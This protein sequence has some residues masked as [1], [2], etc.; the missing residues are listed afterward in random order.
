M[1]DLEKCKNLGRRSYTELQSARKGF[2][3]SG[4]VQ[5]AVGTRSKWTET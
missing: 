5:V 2:L 1:V 4:P 3:F